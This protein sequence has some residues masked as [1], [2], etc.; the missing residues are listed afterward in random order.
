MFVELFPE[1]WSELTIVVPK[2]IIAVA[3]LGLGWILGHLLG[4]GLS[5]L[6][7]KVGFEDLLHRTILGKALEQSGTTCVKFFEFTIRWVVYLIAILL[8]VEI[9]QV[10]VLRT[11][12]QTAPEYLPNIV[13]G[14]IIL[15]I[16]LVVSDFIA[17]IA[18]VVGA[19]AKVEL[20]GLLSIGLRL[21]GYYVVA[22]IALGVMKI[23]I[24]VL[25]TIG[26]ALAW[27]IALGAGSAFGIAFGFGLKDYVARNIEQWVSA[28][29]EVAKKPE[30]FWSWYTR[31]KEEK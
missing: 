21:I 24:T 25:N 3:I 2:F 20:A 22:V 30:D 17:D 13:A 5:R 29:R 1:F 23:D 31:T 11:L 14:F 18:R 27:G 28:T 8:A 15:F 7:V 6:L 16:G 9:F 4:K 26:N 19:E 10:G 12:L